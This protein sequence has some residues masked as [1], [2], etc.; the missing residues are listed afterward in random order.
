MSTEIRNLRFEYIKNWPKYIITFQ[1]EKEYIKKLGEFN[2]Q[3]FY[4]LEYPY[5]DDKYDNIVVSYFIDGL[6]CLP[7]KPNQA[8]EY[9]FRALDNYSGNKFNIK[10]NV[11][12]K[13]QKVS[14]V[15][16]ENM[17]SNSDLKI[18][19]SEAFKNMPQSTCQ[20]LYARLFKEYNVGLDIGLQN[21]ENK[22]LLKRLLDVSSHKD[23]STGNTIYVINNEDTRKIIVHLANTY[24]YCERHY[25][26]TIRKG[27]RFLYRIFNNPTIDIKNDVGIVERISITDKMKIELLILGIIY[28][29]RN[30]IFHGANISSLNSSNTSMK[31][32]AHNHYVMLFT[33]SIINI[34]KADTTQDTFIKE[35]I[36]NFKSNI[37][38]FSRLYKKEIK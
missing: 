6:G 27:S 34:L 36:E 31:T 18:A 30:D 33:F 11:T 3:I 14:N 32:Y 9:F 2:E 15:I 37:N 17:K 13:L 16:A 28:T 22:Q 24:G 35:V 5:S 29:M 26:E 38:T 25:P 1:T 23:P 7:M 12:S 8:F 19:I 20:Y 4:S 21:G 10:I